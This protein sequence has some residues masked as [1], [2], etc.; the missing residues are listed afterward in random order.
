MS[1]ADEKVAVADVMESL[2]RG[3]TGAELKRFFDGKWHLRRCE[4]CDGETFETAGDAPIATLSVS[5]GM[6]PAQLSSF[7]HRRPFLQIS[8]ASCGNT[9]FFDGAIVRRWLDS[10]T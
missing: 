5:K 1:D 7:G 3:F 8:C 10:G 2:E 4:V 9:K 6:L